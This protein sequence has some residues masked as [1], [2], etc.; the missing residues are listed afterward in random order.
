MTATVS[1]PSGMR[2]IVV[3]ARSQRAL[4]ANVQD[5]LLYL[6]SGTVELPA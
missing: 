2:V 4:D 6:L 5:V 1:D 3:A